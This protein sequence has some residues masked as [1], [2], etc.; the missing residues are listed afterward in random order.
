[1]FVNHSRL[2]L[3]WVCRS[4]LDSCNVTNTE[5]YFHADQQKFNS[6]DLFEMGVRSD[7][8]RIELLFS[9]LKIKELANHDI[10][11]IKRSTQPSQTR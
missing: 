6:V 10:N 11:I 2:Y 4:E 3:K 1:M 9:L 7:N 5:V 8:H